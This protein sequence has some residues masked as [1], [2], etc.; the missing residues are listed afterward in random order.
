MH[1]FLPIICKQYRN[2]HDFRSANPLSTILLS[3]LSKQHL[4]YSSN[5]L[6]F[7]DPDLSVGD[8]QQE[9]SLHEGNRKDSET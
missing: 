7:L 5:S 9:T 6:D 2:L 8:M 4:P 3:L 1:Q